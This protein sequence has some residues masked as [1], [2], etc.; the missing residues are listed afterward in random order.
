MVAGS[1][2]ACLGPLRSTLA[3]VSR[4]LGDAAAAE[5]HLAGAVARHAELALPGLPAPGNPL[6]SA[7]GCRR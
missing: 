6:L 3:R 4:Y 5:A 1:A 2:L 7:V